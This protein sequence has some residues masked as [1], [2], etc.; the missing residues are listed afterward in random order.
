MQHKKTKIQFLKFMLMLASAELQ[1]K[2]TFKEALIEWT[3]DAV[4]TG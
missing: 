1:I 4:T 2:L 3:T